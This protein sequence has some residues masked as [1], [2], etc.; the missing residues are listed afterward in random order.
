MSTTLALEST[1]KA[2]SPPSERW[3]RIAC[4]VASLL[5]AWPALRLLA[6][7]WQSTD[8]LAHGY[9]IPLTS[10]GLIWLRREQIGAALRDAVSPPLGP[11]AVLGAALLQAGA[12]LAEAGTLSGVGLVLTI[13]ATVYAVGGARLARELLVPVAFLLLMVPPPVAVADQLLF[14]LKAL[15]IN[16]SVWLLQTTGFSIAATGNRLFVPGHE[17]FVANACSG[18][19]SIVTL[20]PL[21]VVVAYLLSHG[22]W[23]R[24]L[25][26]ASVV[27]IA[28]A[29]NTARVVIT[30]VLVSWWGMD[31]AEGLLHESFG[32]ITFVL[33]TVV[34]VGLARLLRG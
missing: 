32:L 30:V 27:P 33:G 6:Y 31:Y 25:L 29:G 19:T 16:I 22:V 1:A 14:G 18:L 21:A 7:I 28:I 15:T 23:R 17:L 26:V 11:L 20:T 5:A 10:A 8:Y 12:V 2:P 9:L 24:L 4:L 34:L 13:A 3:L